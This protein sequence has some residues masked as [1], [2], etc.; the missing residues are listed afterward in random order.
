[1]KRIARSVLATAILITAGT[2]ASLA[3]A[4]TAQAISVISNPTVGPLG[5][6][7][8]IGDSVLVGAGIYA[9]NLPARL[10]EQ[11]WGP[12]Q[13]RAGEGYSTG[14]FGV[15]STFKAS[16][17]IQQWRQQGW[18]APNVIV[19]LG[20]NDSGFCNVNLQC[21]RD[22]IM[23]LVNAIGPGHEIWWPQITRLYTHANQQNNWNTALAQIAA[24]RDDFHTWDW[25]TEMA[26]GPYPSS[27]GTHLAPS[28][29]RTRSLMMAEVFTATL[30]VAERVGG[31]APLPDAIGSASSFVPLSPERAVDTRPTTPVA[32]GTTL[33]VDLG[34]RIPERA[35]AVAVN[36]TAT[37]SDAA[38]YLTAHPCDRTRRDVS[39]VNYGARISRGS[40]AVVPLAGNGTFCVFSS[41]TSHVLVDLQGVF[42]PTGSGSGAGAETGLQTISTP[43]RIADTRVTG[44]VGTLVVS[45]PPGADAVAVNLTADAAHVDG[46]LTAFPCDVTKPEVSNVNFLAGEPVAGAAFVPTSDA[47][48]I[49]VF[50]STPVDV[51]VDLTGTF[52]TGTGL[53]FVPA[54]PTRTIDT[55]DATGGW[56]P[57][58]G[59]GQTIDA[60][61][62][63]P[64]AAA[65]TGTLTL[66]GPTTA[67][68]LTTHPCTSAPT[69]SVNAAK[70]I[71]LANSLTIAVTGQGRLCIESF[72]PG[73]TLF[74]TTGW[75]V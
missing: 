18:D 3:P 35:T 1:M 53:Q 28:G 45:T 8:V 41:A 74:D 33:T 16:Y 24:E 46:Y 42:V 32:A 13:F 2:I 21:A 54:D 55:R 72:A 11:G 62:A 39:S 17:W 15:Q 51:I 20:A 65:V 29:Y 73:T 27:D 5:P 56:A 58:H 7:T 61:V 12:V 30:A 52:V 37:G 22:A 44:R 75:W 31:D 26:S 63:P 4:G 25:P 14:Q 36:I 10:V 66:V 43:D 47:N 23:H 60:R 38:G 57:I 68:Y 70:G 67:S 64:G 40:M 50:S 19:N 9:P 71:D 48:T 6:V 49:C 34:E 59:A 69:S